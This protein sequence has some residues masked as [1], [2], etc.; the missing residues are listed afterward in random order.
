MGVGSG[1]PEHLILES[2]CV[3]QLEATEREVRDTTEMIQNDE[4]KG[5]EQR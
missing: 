5:K 1:Y 4:E 3:E 2:K